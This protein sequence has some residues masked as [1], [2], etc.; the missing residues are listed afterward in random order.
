MLKTD[1]QEVQASTQLF[2]ELEKVTR[3]QA[4]HGAVSDSKL[5]T[6]DDSYLF[7]S[8]LSCFWHP[9]HIEAKVRQL[10][11]L[12][13]DQYRD[14]V[15]NPVDNADRWPAP[16]VIKSLSDKLFDERKHGPL[17]LA[18]GEIATV[19]GSQKVAFM[20]QN[21]KADNGVWGPQH[22]NLAADW[23]REMES[24]GRPI[25]TFM[26]TPGA[27]AGEVANLNNQAHS[28]S[29]LIAVIADVTVPV[30]SVVLGAGYSGGA[31]P[32]AAGNVL[33]AVKDALFNTIQPK[34]LAAIARKQRLSWYAC[35][36]QVGLSAAELCHNGILDAVVDYSPEE[37]NNQIANLVDA[38][39]EAI[40]WSTD[41][42][43]HTIALIPPAGSAY[44]ETSLHYCKE[45]PP[46]AILH[47]YIPEHYPSIIAYG[48]KLQRSVVLRSRLKTATLDTLAHETD[49][50]HPS[51][52]NGDDE[53]SAIQKILDT[54]FR[55][56][57]D[58]KERLIYEDILL[59]GWKRFQESVEHRGEKRSYVA[60]LFLGDPEDEYE[61][62][63]RELC[64]EVGFYLYNRWQ[65]DSV[66]HLKRLD[67][68]L[69]SDQPEYTANQFAED[70][71]TLLDVIRD[72]QFAEF[73]RTCCQHL[74]RLD[75]LYEVTLDRMTAIVTE[76]AEHQ[77]LSAELMSDL[78]DR[79]GIKNEVRIAFLDWLIQVRESGNLS[80]Y[81]QV[82][83]HW[84]R[85]QHSRMSEVLFVV[86]SYFFDRL[87]PDYFV[88]TR[89]NKAFGGQFTPV[90][91]GR[92]KDFWN[93]L[94]EAEKDLR[95][96]ALLNNNKPARL[97]SPSDL[98]GRY[99]R[100]FREF[101]ADLTT[102]NPCQFPGFGKALMRQGKAGLSASGVIT[103]VAKF[104]THPA[105]E[106]SAPASGFREVGVVVSNHGF[107][108]GAFDMSSAERVCR[109][110]THCAKHRLPVVCFVCS[111][112]MQTKEGAG[113]LFSMA[114]VNEHFNR[115]VSE[116]R[117][118]ILVFGYG[119]CTGGAQASFVTHPLVQTW[120][121]SGTNIPFAG[122]IVVPNFLPVTATLANYLVKKEGSMQ[123]LV[124]HP[125][126][127]DLD[128]Q[129]AAI[130]N[131]IIL[132]AREVDEVIR[133]WLSSSQPL[134]GEPEDVSEVQEAAPIF[135]SFDKVLVHARGCTAVKLVQQIQRAGLN[136]C[137][138]QSDPDMESVAAGMLDLDGGDE[139]V[140]LGGYTSDESYLN[141]D[142]VL[143]IAKLQNVTALHPGIGF[144]SENA[145]FAQQC[146]QQGVNFIGPSPKSMAMM[147]DKSQAIKT[148]MR[149][150]VPVVPG[151]H[152]VLADETHALKIARDIG[153]P[154]ILKAAHG[155]G[156]KGIVV[157]EDEKSLVAKFLTIKAEA[158]SSFGNDDIYLERFVTRFRHIEVQLLRDRY[159][160]CFALGV[161]DCSVQ[162]NKQKIIEES[163]STLL[164]PEKDTL[165]RECAINLANACEYVGAGTVEFIFDLDHQELYF[166][167]M[168]TRLQ[169]EHP[170]TELV[171]GVNI[172]H[173]Q[174]LIAQGESIE[175]LTIGDEGYALE[176][177]INAEHVTVS[178][179]EISVEPTPGRV[180]ACVLPEHDAVTGI[181]TVAEGKSVPPYYDNLIAQLIAYGT[182]RNDAIAKMLAY[183][184]E[185]RIDGIST[186]I[187]LLTFILADEVFLGGD[188]DTGYLPNLAMREEKALVAHLG[189]SAVY[190]KMDWEQEIKVEGSDELKVFAPSN[191]ILYRS[192]APNKPQFVEE[193]D[194]IDVDQ[195]L[196][197]LEVM[198]MFQP[199][200]LSSFNTSGAELYPANG[201]Y[202]VTH[203]KGVDGQQ[204][205]KGDL[206]FVVRPV[207]DA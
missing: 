45:N 99:F 133:H 172:V 113:S 105:S 79:A 48:L 29:R 188:Y 168:N 37:G 69:A 24:L 117:L 174:L 175:G 93:R 137:L 186:N 55:Q 94:V 46:P 68:Y 64:F 60:A 171:S 1:K 22:H 150:N 59:R 4:H 58:T 163:G 110:L 23:V 111:G 200:S 127:A 104:V 136:A 179:A 51:K 92:R 206:L 147:G 31:I 44:L 26:D 43:R 2:A 66:H 185:T 199:L 180:D 201:R 3:R 129:L 124:K 52:D 71:L 30:V 195:T 95:I 83:E 156:G 178:K 112:G 205:N 144:L 120:Y 27:D 138:V 130:D 166:M 118:P 123:G 39:Q 65:Q 75:T 96:Q 157:V 32:L 189:E 25:V 57:L 202:R 155:G 78:L 203:V 158:R 173:Q 145:G 146:L 53:E 169:V 103:G 149:L 115:F 90:S 20:G 165:A 161:R 98:I 152:G 183:L 109:L 33:L 97:F 102:A 164:P 204:V 91:I 15:I 63:Y 8:T 116:V 77:R 73:V 121:F 151:S 119:D 16:K 148:A 88:A 84:K 50:R 128:S 114:V 100:D 153:F 35:A 6:A 101:D 38:I 54:R 28:I 132:A 56:W 74:I 134:E 141:G 159:G 12:T 170:V 81:M 162:R 87:F 176:V 192:S 184:K 40:S 108:A 135:G 13:S 125:F 89:D 193:G 80:R 72:K 10:K 177:R 122:R 106:D 36:Q 181:V 76:L 11:S 196:C 7:S 41:K 167:E 154:V 14:I 86:V 182:D 49:A 142:S 62:A 194:T 85:S 34:G 17:Y 187:G 70:Q 47:E 107:Q 198:K 160:H 18:Q 21:R 197:L 191:S 190:Q 207:E 5:R 67:S 61:K 82:A 139:L 140:C 42:A 9:E 19:H 126:M 131:D 143:R